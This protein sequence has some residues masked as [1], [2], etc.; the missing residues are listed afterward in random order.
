MT[1]FP[2]SLL[3]ALLFACAPSFALAQTD[4][5]DRRAQ[6]HF[7][8]ATAYFEEGDYERASIEF[9]A[10]YAA[11]P[12]PELL[13][14]IYM[15]EERLA[16]LDLAIDALE[17][18]LASDATIENRSALEA[19]LGHLRERAAQG[20]T[21]TDATQVDATPAE[22]IPVPTPS[23]ASSGPHPLA[24]AGFTVA[25]VGLVA[26]AILGGITLSEDARLRGSCGHACSDA[27]TSLIGA[28]GVGAD[29]SA[30]VAL[31]G[32][33]LGVVGL[34]LPTGTSDT[35]VAVGPSGVS[36]RGSF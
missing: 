15:S 21:T 32:A 29:V 11:S 16:H 13:F 19:R 26:F 33:I 24:I 14:N 25:G 30:G 34:V 28:T 17:Q 2:S 31:A 36:I 9:R 12:H 4:D 5:V 35:R 18:Y 8:A 23:V 22:A 7:H 1:R 3:L 6:A 27:D 10:A 20:E